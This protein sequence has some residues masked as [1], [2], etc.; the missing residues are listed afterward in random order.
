MTIRLTEKGI[1]GIIIRENNNVEVVKTMEVSA[2]KKIVAMGV[3]AAIYIVLSRFVAIP[4]PVP[5]ITI[6]VTF[7]FLALMAF[8]YGPVVAFGVG[9]IGHTI[10]DITAYGSPW[11]SWI[12][13]TGFFGF[14]IG[15]L[16]KSIKIEGFNKSKIVRFIIGEL[17]ICMITWGIIAPGL[18]IVMY[19]EP[20][21]KVFLQGAT[22]G[23]ING[24]AVAV[25]GTI[26]I[27]GFSKTIVKEGSL[28]KEN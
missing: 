18:D 5:N 1:N 25:L 24:L 6:Q 13:A 9:F 28:K 3:G 2:I 8:I 14:A 22:A 21:N 17:V 26:L 11:F 12:I 27:Y 15:L 7:A 20:A 16:G 19:K 10:S 23:I 4:T